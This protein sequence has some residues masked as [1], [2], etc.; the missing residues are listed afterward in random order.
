VVQ[1]PS[2]HESGSAVDS[3]SCLSQLHIPSDAVVSSISI[4]ELTPRIP[5]YFSPSRTSHS[6][7]GVFLSGSGSTTST[8]S[9]AFLDGEVSYT[10]SLTFPLNTTACLWRN[11]RGSMPSG[12]CWL[13]C[14]KKLVEMA[15]LDSRRL[16]LV[17]E[18]VLLMLRW[19]RAPATFGKRPRR[20]PYGPIAGVVHPVR[21]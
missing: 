4:A 20:H 10:S 1:L 12:V 3:Q 13:H 6:R 18:L 16:R 11:G 21:S 9:L 14:M 17:M 19:I 15:I 8:L 2:R 7:F 5:S